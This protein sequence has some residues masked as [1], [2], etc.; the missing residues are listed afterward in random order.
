[1]LAYESGV[2]YTV[3]PFAGSYLI[4]NPTD[5][6][7]ARSWE[8]IDKVEQLGGS[9]N[10]LQFIPKETEESA[11]SYQERYRTGR[12]LVVGVNKS[13]PTRWTMSTSSRWTPGSEKRQL[14][15]PKKWKESRDQE[16]VDARLDDL[17]KVA[18]GNGNLL[19]RSRR[20]DAPAA[21]SAR[22]AARC[23]TSSASTTA[24]RSSR[25]RAS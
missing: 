9:V 23:A 13:S 5:D 15:R 12:Y 6:I 17:G 8:L 7:E 2:A 20:R 3:D 10:A 21:R 11:I 1:V 16:E 22:C 14:A 19:S 25:R 24:A 18:E 4:E